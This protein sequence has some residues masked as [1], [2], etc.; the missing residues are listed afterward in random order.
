M[1]TKINKVA[2][3]GSGIMGSRIACHFAN[4]GVEVLLLDIVPKDAGDDK[5][6]RN[7]IVN[8]ALK[9]TLKSNPAPLYRKSYISRITTGN[10][11]DNL[12]DIAD[13]DWV[14]EVVI[15]RLDIKKQVF[16]NVEKYRKKGSFISSNTSGIPINL[17]NEGRSEDFQKYFCGT[18]FFNPPRYMKLLEIIPTPK[19]DPAVID[20]MMEYGRE[21][22]GKTTVLCKDTP[23]FIANRIGSYNLLNLLHGVKELGM[24]PSEVDKL[25]GAVMGRAKSGTFRT[26]D[27]VGIDT[28]VHVANGLAAS[29]KEDE[30]V[31]RFVI[32]DFV[33][34]LVDNKWLGSKT[35]QGFYKKA[36]NDKG[37]KVILELDFATMEYK[38]PG[39]VEFQTLTDAKKV[40]DLDERLRVLAAGKDKAGEFYRKGFY[41]NF[42]YSANRIPEIAD[43]VYKI[44]AA[45]CAGYGWER[46]PFE[47]WDVLGFVDTYKAMKDA[48]YT[49]AKWVD[50]M[51]DAGITSFYKIEGG[52]KKFYD[53]ESKSY[54]VIPG[55]ESLIQL[56][57]IRDEKTV[58][59]NSGA[60]IIDLGDGILNVE[61]RTKMNMLNTEAVEGLTTAIDMAEKDY[62][63]LV[64]SN[65]GA[66]FCAGAD[67]G[68]IFKLSM[69]QDID[70]LHNAVKDFQN[71]MM[72]VR[73]SSI[74]V[75]TAPHNMALGGG[76]EINLHADKVVAHAETY[77]GLVEFGVGLIPAGGGT[78]EMARRLSKNAKPNDVEVNNFYANMVT[79][80]QAK[81]SSSAA[82][83]FDF[84]FLVEGRD[85][86]VVSR[87]LLLTRAKNSCLALAN[88][89]YV[90]PLKEKDIRVLGRQTYALA[91]IIGNSMKSGGYASEHDEL[92]VQKLGYVMAG[93]DLSAP[94][95]VS[96][97]YLLD[98]EREAF[99]SLCQEMKTFERLKS[100]VTTG[101]VLRN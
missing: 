34:T 66:N 73:Y 84:G 93:G 3:L 7:Q 79:V 48:G 56:D 91:M 83:A 72:R 69:E 101:K 21:F 32:P 11:D 28:L 25:T 100:M 89:G 10:F 13:C 42:S 87:E 80:G 62:K 20:F 39:K 92:I 74:P 6:K 23:G 8:D 96:E 57:N 30:K 1:N 12:K 94:T 47:T 53:I 77:M 18:H 51:V 76:C 5:K 9:F 4:I 2:V 64:V 35:G 27:V 99:V 37:K 55:T 86:I 67:I 58:W 78:K 59:K 52:H 45:M 97:Q 75:V 46:G 90:K 38:E 16:E 98:L 24:T 88:A 17:M 33:Q 14:I 81:V 49:H 70:G 44:D 68:Q 22:L 29:C 26:C 31:D 54:K 41:D 19:T 43:E 36:K 71:A 82:E 50:E 65:D 85:E 40:E 61:F 95:M 15:E 63:G 60:S